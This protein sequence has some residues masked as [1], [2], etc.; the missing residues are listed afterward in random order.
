MQQ[1]CRSIVCCRAEFT[2][3]EN[4]AKGGGVGRLRELNP[5]PDMIGTEPVV[6]QARVNAMALEPVSDLGQADR[7]IAIVKAE[8]N[9]VHSF[10]SPLFEPTQR[11][12][13]AGS[14]CPLFDQN[15][16][17]LAENGWELP[18]GGKPAVWS[19]LR[20]PVPEMGLLD[21]PAEPGK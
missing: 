18:G 11:V 16:H 7:E 10:F 8:V 5:K 4:R 14:T 19:T 1:R 9:R 2:L 17:S 15:C 3:P 12:A 20:L 13:R 6:Q 21:R